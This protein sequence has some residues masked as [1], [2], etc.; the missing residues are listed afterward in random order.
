[1]KITFKLI[2]EQNVKIIAVEKGVEQ[3]VGCIFTPSSSGNN[4]KNAIQVCGFSEAFDFWGCA[5]YSQPKSLDVRE[6]IMDSLENK[7]EEFKQVKDIQLMFD[8]ETKSTAKMRSRFSYDFD[9]DCIACFNKPCTCENKG[10]HKHISPYN[11]KR[12]EDLK[13][14]LEYLKDKK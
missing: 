14:K 8:I 6:K 3:E 13:D 7:K 12:E 4:I 2:D 10:N 5:R 1:M 11:V 9:K